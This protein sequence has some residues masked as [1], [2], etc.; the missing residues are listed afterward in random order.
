MSIPAVLGASRLEGS[1]NT[2]P[3]HGYMSGLP[4]T[5]ITA[6]YALPF[7]LLLKVGGRPNFQSSE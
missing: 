2:G 6:R 3:G 7:I 5:L 4:G 1:R